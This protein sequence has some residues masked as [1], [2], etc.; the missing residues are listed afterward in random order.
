MEKCSGK[1]ALVIN[2]FA[3]KDYRIP[4]DARN[5]MQI[6]EIPFLYDENTIQPS[7]KSFEAIYNAWKESM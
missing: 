7:K 6:S 2:I 5:G 1:H 4:H 3:E